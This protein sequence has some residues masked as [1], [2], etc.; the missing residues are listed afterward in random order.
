M[1]SNNGNNEEE[2][3]NFDENEE[4]G[5]PHQTGNVT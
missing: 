3:V 2:Y 1:N 4:A 5:N